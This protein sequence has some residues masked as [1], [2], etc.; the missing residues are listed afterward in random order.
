MTCVDVDSD[1]GKIGKIFI[2]NNNNNNN[3]S[4][5]F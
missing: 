2:K 4:L 3:L 1:I 5:F